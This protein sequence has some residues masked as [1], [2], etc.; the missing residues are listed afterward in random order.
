MNP[1]CACGCCQGI[2]I[3]APQ[4]TANRPGLPALAYRIGTHGTFLE[5]MIARLSSRDFPPL[6]ALKTRDPSDPAIALLDGWAV[7][8]DVLSFYQE[9]IVNEGYL[10]TATERRS[11]LELARLLG[12]KLRPGV[13][14]TVYLAYT[15]AEDLSET[16]PGPTETLIPAGSRSQSV[17]GPGQQPQFF[18]TSDD[19]DARSEWNDLGVRLTQPQWITL[20]GDFDTKA[21]TRDA[22]YFSGTATNLQPGDPLMFILGQGPDQQV[23]R[24]VQSVEIQSAQTRT[25]IILQPPPIPPVKVGEDAA[26]LVS[27]AVTPYITDAAKLFPGTSLAAQAAALL[28]NSPPATPGLLQQIQSSQD[29]TGGAVASLVQSAI[30]ALSP[31]RDLAVTRNFTRLEPWLSQMLDTLAAVVTELQALPAAGSSAGANP[32]LSAATGTVKITPPASL[33]NLTNL[34]TALTAP[35][36]VQPANSLRLTRTIEQTFA[37]DSDMAPRLLGAFLPSAAPSLYQAWAGLETIAAAVEIGAVRL[38]T[39]L[40][41]G[42]YPGL[43][44]TVNGDGNIATQFANP[45][46]IDSAWPGLVQRDGD[47]YLPLATIALDA[48]YGKITAGSWIMIDYPDFTFRDG[49]VRGLSTVEKI[50]RIRTFHKVVSATTTSMTTQDGGFSAKV[51]QLTLDR[52]WLD[53]TAL[54]NMSGQAGLLSG[55]VVYAQTEILDLAEEPIDADVEGDTIELDGV[56]DGLESGRWIIVS[57]ERTDIPNVT[58]VTAGELAMILGVTQVNTSPNKQPV[59]VHTV[60]TLANT[61]AY[62]CDADTVTIYGN[63]VKAT[64]GQTNNET[65]GNGDGGQSFQEFT[66]KQK[67]LTFVP[68]SNP[69]GATTTLRVYVN[70]VEWRE[71]D[72]LAG[73]G[74]KDRSYVTQ[75]ADDDSTTVIFGNGRQGARPPTGAGNVTAVYRNGICQPGNVD[76][77]QISLLQSRPLNVKA[78]INP[79]PASGGADRDTLDQARRNTPLAVMSL[80]RLVSVQD[81]A[82]FAL[83]FA[84]IGKASSAKLSDGQRDLAHVTI[85]GAEDIPIDPS[86]DLYTNLGQA[87]KTNGDPYQPLELAVRTLKLLIISAR[88]EVLADYLWEDVAADL[89]TTLLDTFSFDNRNLGQP[90]FQSEVISAMQAVAGVAYVDL[91]KLDSVAENSITADPAGLASNLRKRHIVPAALASRN[92]SPGNYPTDGILPAELVYL[93]PTLPDTLILTNVNS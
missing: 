59:P 33:G 73:L 68:A 60:L 1:S 32:S 7:V 67:P 36:S 65:L 63:V 6:A 64:H 44:T 15:L 83:T 49:A 34:L 92:P 5:T 41:P 38:K 27:A 90:V 56:Y 31:L 48:V 19:L 58:G 43:P 93:S 50:S 84:G 39:G 3:A 11:V 13:A 17:P 40:F 82:D 75:T 51:T 57:G 55:T 79:L 61:L 20:L 10:R 14:A 8:A 54:E 4:P 24:L 72:T 88:V 86:S 47:A 81:Y 18:E 16:P 45:P 71:A 69:E 25:E 29:Q 76:A 53:A 87:L 37:G 22:V 12:Y 42:S 91:L 62:L 9:R 52:P 77:N 85:A 26:S 30:T 70:N 23:L 2:A 74:A 66:L 46:T 78:V 28:S 35:A 89:R 21:A 80:D